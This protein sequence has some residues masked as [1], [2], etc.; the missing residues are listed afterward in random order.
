MS[1]G[2][3]KTV[4]TRRAVQWENFLDKIVSKIK[5][6]GYTKPIFKIEIERLI[7]KNSK[8]KEI[9]EEV[10]GGFKGIEEVNPEVKAWMKGK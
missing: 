1:N 6:N 5:E 7:L 3:C 10:I 9:G 4:L 8:I 2:E